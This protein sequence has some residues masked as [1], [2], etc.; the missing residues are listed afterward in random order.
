VYCSSEVRQA[1][2][3]L[4]LLCAYSSRDVMPQYYFQITNRRYAEDNELMEMFYIIHGA[5]TTDFGYAWS[6]SINQIKTLYWDSVS[7][8]FNPSKRR[9]NEWTEALNELTQRL[10]NHMLN[11][12]PQS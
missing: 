2:A 9:I 5:A 12:H 3:A 8:S 10:S 4:E 7:T 6:Q 11:T 1:A